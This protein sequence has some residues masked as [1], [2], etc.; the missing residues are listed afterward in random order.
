MEIPVP[1]A[2]FITDSSVNHVSFVSHYDPT[3]IILFKNRLP[4]WFVANHDPIR[5][6]RFYTSTG[7]PRIP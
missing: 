4:F 2:Y 6:I 1:L 5:G 3:T 7:P